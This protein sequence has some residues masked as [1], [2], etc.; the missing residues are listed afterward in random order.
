MFD[1]LVERITEDRSGKISVEQFIQVWLEADNILVQKIQ[2]IQSKISEFNNQKNSYLQKLNLAKKTEILN[3]FGIMEV[4]NIPPRIIFQGSQ[5]TI[6]IG[7]GSGQWQNQTIL[8]D[9]SLGK[10]SFQTRA[11][12]GN[13]VAWNESFAFNVISGQE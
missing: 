12:K 5:L 2:S 1:Q 8:V 10:Q 6:T 7:K 3:E 4:K 9:L 13:S 11:L